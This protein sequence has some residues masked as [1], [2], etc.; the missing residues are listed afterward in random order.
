MLHC[1]VDLYNIIIVYCMLRLLR[2]IHFSFT[3]WCVLPRT[4]AVHCPERVLY[5]VWPAQA[6]ARVLRQ[7]LL[8]A[9]KPPTTVIRA[10]CPVYREDRL[11]YVR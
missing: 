4:G 2:V 8:P 10:K 3:V 6:L 5:H 1:F 7:T 9:G 11:W